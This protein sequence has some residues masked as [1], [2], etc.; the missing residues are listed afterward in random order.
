MA[1]ITVDGDGNSEENPTSGRPDY[2]YTF[3]VAYA[4]KATLTIHRFKN[5]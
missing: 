1:M 5:K 3:L 4:P 2:D